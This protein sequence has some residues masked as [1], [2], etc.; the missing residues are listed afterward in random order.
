MRQ[1]MRLMQL[2]RNHFFF[3]GFVVGLILT[4]CLPDNA[5]EITE[6]ECPESFNGDAPKMMAQDDDFEPRLNLVNKP[7]TAKKT[8]KNIIRPRY[9]SSELGIR[10]K[11]FI[12]V[13]TNQRHIN[14][15]ATAFNRTTAHHVDKIKYF[16]NAADNV[17]TNFKLKNIVGFTDVRDHLK[18]FHILKY[19]ADNY[20]DDYD[21]FL[22]ATDTT[23]VNARRLLKQLNHISISFDVYIGHKRD[24]S[25]IV[26]SD[27]HSRMM[28]KERDYCDLNAGIILSS[29]LIRKIRSNLDW[30]VRNAATN[31][32]SLNIG[33][34]I[35]YSSKISGCQQSFQ[36]IQFPN[37]RL[38]TYKLYRD[39]HFLYSDPSFNNASMVHPVKTAEDFYVLHSYFSKLNLEAIHAE[40]QQLDDAVRQIMNGSISNDILQVRWPLGVPPPSKPDT[41]YDLRT[42]SLMNE[43]HQIMPNSEQN[44]GL[45]SRIDQ[46][47]I[48]RVLSRTLIE[49]KKIYPNLIYTD[50]HSIY[51]RFDPVRGM[52]Y[53]LHL[54]FSE[55]HEGNEK[56]IVKSFEAVKP[57]GR[58]EI[59]PSPYV[60]E[61]TRV[62][63]LLPTFEHQTKETLDFIAQY[64]KTCMEHQDNTF[65]MMVLLYQANS[66][67]KAENDVFADLKTM[68]L[69]LSEKYKNDG[70]RI[71]WVSVRLP[72][73]FSNMFRGSHSTSMFSSMYGSEEILSLVVTDLALRKI[74]LESLVLLC[75]NSMSFKPD[76]LNRVRMSTIQGFQVFSPIGFVNYPCKYTNLCRECD[77]CDVSQSAGYFDRTNS[78]V[79]SFYSRDYVTVRKAMES[80]VPI[81][82]SDNH[83][84][85]ILLR[86]DQTIMN[87]LDLFIKSK[88]GIHVMRAIE[89]NLRLG[90]TIKNYLNA[91]NTIPQCELW[92]TDQSSK[93]LR[94][95]SRKQI[96]DS[97]IKY[98][99]K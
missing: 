53:Q 43:T 94:I 71:A 32:D 9:Y 62:A 12:G 44:I 52:D 22:L 61:S 41:R 16:I 18:P 37:Y 45:L 59:V 82:R 5:W 46:E 14:S 89:P 78:D 54:M 31:S 34:C 92:D 63:L 86:E 27:E 49:A 69:Q 4:I 55:K 19:I 28:E 35:K 90:R 83:I 42:W 60:T 50:L 57:L 7:M 3:I 56:I 21:F 36:G 98:Q 64:E 97:I 25:D 81:A 65:L 80:Q 13:L 66:P 70:S 47:D 6:Q 79:I 72:E 23:Y 2:N 1:F 24:A 58:V 40:S 77:T 26:D 17:R 8:A 85:S 39:L 29:S 93:C 75:S 99:N 96:G 33:R 15:L 84:E 87:I 10:E 73:K 95:A 20:L 67:S 91:T 88:S 38:H 30:C 51:R 74:G 76:V 11:L 48:K 68:A